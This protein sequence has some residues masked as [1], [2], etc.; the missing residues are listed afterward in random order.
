MLS[1]IITGML[2]VGIIIGI[3]NGNI[4]KIQMGILDSAPNALKICVSIGC[5]MALWSGVMRIAEKSGITDLISKILR[6]VIRLLFPIV[7]K[8]SE[9][10]KYI[11]MNITANMLGLSNAA[12]P[13]GIKAAEKL[14]QIDK[15]K[16][17]VTLFIIINCASVQ[18]IP[19][20]V[21]AIR[22]EAGSKTPF[23]IVIPVWIASFLTLLFA[24]FLGKIITNIKK[25]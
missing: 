6:P 18:L 2:V 7:K 9:C 25:R 20:T 16:K 4:D 23:D 12:T 11:T 3:I 22:N 24:V 1:Y 19:T 17:Y 14:N 15:S 5:M 10:E 21:A 13:M 8:G